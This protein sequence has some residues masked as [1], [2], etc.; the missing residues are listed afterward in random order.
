MVDDSHGQV[1]A[2]MVEAVA[3]QNPLGRVPLGPGDDRV[4]VSGLVVLVLFAV[5]LL[6][7]MVMEVWRPGFSGQHIAAIAFIPQRR[8]YSCR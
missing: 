7:L 1:S 3:V 8:S 2:G 5:V 4:M 6:R